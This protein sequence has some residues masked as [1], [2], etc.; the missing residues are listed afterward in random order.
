MTADYDRLYRAILQ[1]PGRSVL[2]RTGTG[3]Q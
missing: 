1:H 2:K 3:A